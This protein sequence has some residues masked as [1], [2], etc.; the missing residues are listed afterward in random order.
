MIIKETIY[1]ESTEL[2]VLASN[3]WRKVGYVADI[4]EGEDPIECNHKLKLLADE[5]QK[6]NNVEPAAE[7]PTHT[8]PQ[9]ESPD[10]IAFRT[11]ISKCKKISDLHTYAKSAKG[12][13][14]IYNE[15]LKQLQNESK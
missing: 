2:V 8:P 7:I 3:R 9:G 5:A 15:R 12:M 13:R 11:L 14:D 1:A 4:M 10:R 6:R